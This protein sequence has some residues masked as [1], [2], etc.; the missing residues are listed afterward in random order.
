M[1]LDHAATLNRHC[2]IVVTQPRRLAAVSVC[3]RVCDERG[4]KMGTICGFKFQ[5]DRK[6]SSKTRILYLTTGS[7]I[8]SIISNEDY[9]KKYTHV[10]LDEIHER[11]LDTDLIILLLKIK[12]LG[13]FTGKVIF[14]ISST[15]EVKLN[16]FLLVNSYV[17]YFRSNN[18][19]RI[20]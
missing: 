19:S 13:G 6:L 15:S 1:I 20:F 5:T 17:S 4:W 7:L 10:I 11:D 12:L 2:N 3:K 18:L 9:I 8:Q 16:F 14:I